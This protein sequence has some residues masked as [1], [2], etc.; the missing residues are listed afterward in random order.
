MRWD[1]SNPAA[2]GKAT[3]LRSVALT[4]NA[5]RRLP[6]IDRPGLWLAIGS[7]RTMPD[8]LVL[9]DGKCAIVGFRFTR[10]GRLSNDREICGRIL[11]RDGF[12]GLCD[13]LTRERWGAYVAI[14]PDPKDSESIALYRDPIGAL[15]CVTWQSEGVR[16][17]TSCPERWLDDARPVSLEI[18][19]DHLKALLASPGLVRNGSPLLGV[20]VVQ[21]GCLARFPAAA[22]TERL[23]TPGAWCA[24]HRRTDPSPEVMYAIVESAISA[25]A[26]IYPGAVAEVSGGLDSA[27]VAAIA[28]PDTAYHFSTLQRGGDEREDARAVARHLDIDLIEAMV[29]ASPL[30]EELLTAMP[31]GFRPGLGSTSLF[32]DRPLAQ[33]LRAMQTPALFTGQGGDALFFQP[34]T[35]MI[36]C[37]PATG[38]A[39]SGIAGLLDIA[40]WTRTP[41]TEVMRHRMFARWIEGPAE[42][43]G[44]GVDYVAGVPDRKALG[45]LWHGDVS[46]LGPAK[47]IHLLAIAN[48]QSAFGS[49]WCDEVA[50]VVHPLMSQPIIEHVLGLHAR[51][52][53]QGRRDRA[54]ARSAFAKELPQSL[55]YRRGKG[56]LTAHF[57]LMLARSVP[58]LRNY[59]LDGALASAGLLDRCR[60]EVILERDHLTRF[61]PYAQIFA[62]LLVERWSRG[63]LRR[64]PHA[65]PATRRDRLTVGAGG[66]DRTS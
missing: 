27:V 6:L 45:P 22:S 12:R 7:R 56:S 42:A 59:L 16:V 25:W 49:S 2:S 17:V 40:A 4:D 8:Q 48:M 21:A 9:A 47:R 1:V 50:D 46:Q 37:D 20:D 55:I 51:T 36:A 15:E 32:H 28:R 65:D 19:W 5:L 54:L 23:W 26:S 52:L 41:L 61:D 24:P 3:H 66:N 33:R 34:A 38:G 10:S 57:G 60:L 11:A 63:W 31:V 29:A 62:T 14:M 13:W 58:F 64:I 39:A 30:D 18:D 35:P 53:V 44:N 43:P